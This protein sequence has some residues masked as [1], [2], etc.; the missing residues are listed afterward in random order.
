MTVKKQVTYSSRCSQEL[1]KENDRNAL[2]SDVDI[3]TLVEIENKGSSKEE[4]IISRE[5]NRSIPR[6]DGY[7]I[8]IIPMEDSMDK[9]R[10]LHILW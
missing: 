2:S 9:E 10:N 1:S 7:G 6:S 5:E 4:E 8:I 3:P